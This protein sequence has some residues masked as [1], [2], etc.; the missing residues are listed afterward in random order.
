MTTLGIIPARFASTRLPGKPLAEIHGKPMI[1]HV[2]QGAQTAVD[3][4]IVATDDQRI[5]NVVSDFGGEAMMTSKNH[6]NGTTRCL[7]VVDNL[8]DT[9]DVVVNIQGDEPMIRPEPIRTLIELFT[10]AHVEMGTLAQRVDPS[11][12]P[13]EGGNSVFLTVDIHQRALYFSR[14]VIPFMRDVDPQEWQT[15]F[16]YLKHIGMYAFRPAA[17]RAFA[18]MTESALEKVEKLEQLRWLENG[19]SLH[20]A[21]SNHRGISVDTAEDLDHARKKIQR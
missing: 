20:V 21:L 1:W 16:T 17:L 12:G 4:L 8:S 9:F 2:Y 18:A 5:A 7:E 6:I 15:Q 11:D 19:R 13:L 10:E 3:R 14:H